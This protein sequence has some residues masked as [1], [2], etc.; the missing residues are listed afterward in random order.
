MCAGNH[1]RV[2]INNPRGRCHLALKQF[3]LDR[4]KVAEANIA[5]Y[6]HAPIKETH[7]LKVV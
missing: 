6:Y 2:E 4:E 7:L 3:I 5:A 1:P